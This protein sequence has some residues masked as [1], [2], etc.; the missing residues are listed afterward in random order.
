MA[1]TEMVVRRS[2]T[3][4]ASTE[5]AFAVFTERIADWWPLETHSLKAPD[6]RPDTAIFEQ[7]LGGRLYERTGDEEH[8][9]AYVTAWEPP[10]RIGLDWRVNPNNPPTDVEITFTPEAQGTRVEVVHSGWE[11]YGDNAR[12]SFE[13]YNDGW[14]AVLEAFRRVAD[15]A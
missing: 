5:R 13:S 14:V 7:R 2:V 11:R 1:T 15:E 3:V 10:S 8:L 6:G 9:W 12:E 4:D